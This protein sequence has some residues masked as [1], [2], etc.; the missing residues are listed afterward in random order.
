MIRVACYQQTMRSA[1]LVF[2]VALAGCPATN[3]GGDCNVDS[4]CQPQVCARDGACYDAAD[5]RS[6]KATWTIDGA[7]PST[8]SCN[9]FDLYIRFR[10]P[11]PDDSMGFAPVPCFAGQFTID[12]LPR[13]YDSV[14]LGVDGGVRDT[15]AI[16]ANGD[17]LLDLSL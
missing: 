7:A 4:D 16:D 5:V 6:V 10:G 15:S 2:V 12:K 17:A 14:E 13:R 8:V 9:G 11:S 1:S 3:H